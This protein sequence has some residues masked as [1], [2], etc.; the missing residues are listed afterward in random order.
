MLPFLALVVAVDDA[1][2]AVLHVEGG[3]EVEV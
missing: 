2:V 1:H 3:G